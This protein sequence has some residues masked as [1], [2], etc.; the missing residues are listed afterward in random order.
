VNAN[1]KLPVYLDNHSTTSVDTR[2]LEMM[3]PY[4]S[5]VFGNPASKSHV[6]GRDAHQVVETSRDIIG[7]AINCSPQDL[8][9]TSGATEAVNLAIKGLFHSQRP[10]IQHYITAVTEHPAVIDSFRKI[11]SEGAKITYLKVDKQGLI[12]LEELKSA[13]TPDTQMVCVMAA[14]NE[15]GVLQPISEIGKICRSSNV[16]FMTDATQALGKIH[17]DVQT[18]CIDLLACSAHKIY[19]PKGIGALYCRRSNPNVG[20]VPII[21]GGGHERGLR[22]GTLNVPGIVGFAKA[23]EISIASMKSEQIRIQILRDSLFSNLKEKIPGLNMNGDPRLRLAGNLNIVIPGVP[24]E[25]LIVALAQD[26]AFSTGS[27]CTSLKV[28]PSHVLK[29]IGLSDREAQSSIRLSIGKENTKAELDFAGAKLIEETF[30]L[31][32]LGSGG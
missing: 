24:S 8:C 23:V 31:Q 26:I 7:G 3:L 14:N 2:V 18:M 17:L 6:F 13:I 30:R 27:A 21:D 10:K 29:A 16:I 28:K 19:G 1:L 11:E 4:F 22:S 5:N 25:S 12:A 32:A 20:L 9:F 15:I